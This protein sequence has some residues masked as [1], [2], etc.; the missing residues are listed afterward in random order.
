VAK[1]Q[2]GD[3]TSVRYRS[4]KKISSQEEGRQTEAVLG[5]KEEEGRLKWKKE[6]NNKIL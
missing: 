4:A 1:A 2:I 3:I 6:A 5:G